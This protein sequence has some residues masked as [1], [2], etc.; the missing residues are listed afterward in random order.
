MDL[1]L[2]LVPPAMFF[3]YSAVT[4]TMYTRAK[5]KFI[6]IS[7]FF[8]DEFELFQKEV[9]V[10]IKICI[11][12]PRTCDLCLQTFAV[13]IIFIPLVHFLILFTEQ[14]G[15]AASHLGPFRRNG[16][17]HNSLIIVKK[18]KHFRFLL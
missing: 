8:L 9:Y 12:R 15:G 18:W 4:F 6:D 7:E 10:L 17:S 5:I 13:L 3:I 1:M 2:E 16:P 14:V 11:Y